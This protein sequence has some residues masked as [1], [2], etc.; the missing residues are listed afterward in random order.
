MKNNKRISII[1]GIVFV[2]I[3]VIMYLQKGTNSQKERQLLHYSSNW[4]YN[5]QVGLYNMYEAKKEKI[6]ML[7]DSHTNRVRWD[8]L[9]KID[10]IVN[11]GI[12]GDITAGF[13]NRID[14][15]MEKTRPEYLFIMG[16]YND[17]RKN[18]TV[19]MVFTNF[20]KMIQSIENYNATIVIQSTLHSHHTKYQKQITQLNLLLEKYCQDKNIIFLDLNRHL[21][22]N[23]VLK[24][25]YTHDDVH[26]NANGYRVWGTVIRETFS[27][28][29]ALD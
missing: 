24:K 21:C 3:L 23:N 12:D 17:F 1:L 6:V 26:L 5:V 25:E 7:G 16:G 27:D 29:I 4:N 18:Y 2:I 8:E 20:K 13:L 10:S 19:D 22:P 15:I 9:L 28:S 14:L 11:R